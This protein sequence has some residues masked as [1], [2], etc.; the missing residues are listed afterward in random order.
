[1][2]AIRPSQVPEYLRNTSFYLGLNAIDDDEFSIP[3]HHMKLNTSVDTL[4]DMTELLNTV[5]F[6]GLDIFPE[7]LYEFAS[8]QPFAELKPI[9]ERYHS[10][11]PI[12]TTVCSIVSEVADRKVRLERAMET[13]NLDCV[14]YIHKK[15]G[16][17]FSAIALTLA[18]GKGALNC[19]QYGL[20]T[21]NVSQLNNHNYIFTEAVR[22]GHMDCIAILL[23]K[24]F[25]VHHSY[26]PYNESALAWISASPEISAQSGTFDAQSG[27]PY[28]G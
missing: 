5:R 20:T 3:L 4:A 13:G 27:R 14:R 21:V 15:L 8:L 16:G 22:N 19:L 6:W 26:H 7:A 12:I 17:T 2:Q 25:N 10:D 24:G 1:M 28:P 11:L 18:A 23:Q 9:L